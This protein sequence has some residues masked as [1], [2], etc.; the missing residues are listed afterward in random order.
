[1]KWNQTR[2]TVENLA[3]AMENT[4]IVA[5]DVATD[6]GFPR[7]ELRYRTFGD[8]KEYITGG[9]LRFCNFP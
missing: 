4:K 2:S 9:F 1:M 8:L 7:V 6:T 5:N 3:K